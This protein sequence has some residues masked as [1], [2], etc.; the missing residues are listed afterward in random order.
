MRGFSK[1]K[2]YVKIKYMAIQLIA[3]V[4]T[5]PTQS[6]QDI[7]NAPNNV[8]VVSFSAIPQLFT[9]ILAVAIS[10]LGLGAFLMFIA[11][12]FKYLTSGGDQ[13]GIAQAKGTITFAVVGI[14]VALLA[15][16]MLTYI[17][18]FLGV[19]NITKFVWPV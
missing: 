5:L 8:G 14:V 19:P 10:L 16:L 9:N 4:K 6:L 12:S 11:G 13:K 18:E 17:G 15:Y 7:K 2:Y 3:Q 1:V